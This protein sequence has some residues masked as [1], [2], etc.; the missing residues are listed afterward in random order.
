MWM[1]KRTD[2]AEL[3]TSIDDKLLRLKA[4]WHKLRN[5]SDVSQLKLVALLRRVTHPTLLIGFLALLK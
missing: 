1:T 3:K 5:V 4:C 2:I